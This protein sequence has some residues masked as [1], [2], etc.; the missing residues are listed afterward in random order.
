MI[1][2]FTAVSNHDND[3]DSLKVEGAP[4]FVNENQKKDKSIWKFH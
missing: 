2:A 3:N 1:E 4:A